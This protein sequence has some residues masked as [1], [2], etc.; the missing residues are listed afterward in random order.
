[1]PA[2]VLDELTLIPP[3][4]LGVLLQQRRRARELS[5]DEVAAQGWLLASE[6]DNLEHGRMIV[7]DAIATELARLYR[8]DVGGITPQRSRLIIDL[9]EQRLLVGDRTETLPSDAT[10]HLVLGRYLAMVQLLRAWKPNQPF[11]LRADDLAVLGDSLGLAPAT[12]EDQLRQLLESGQVDEGV[13]RLRRRLVVPAAGLLV[14]TTVAGALVLIRSGSSDPTRDTPASNSESA[15]VAP[16]IIADVAPAETAVADLPETEVP[17]VA[18]EVAAVEEAA[19][20]EE[21][22]AVEQPATV[23]VPAVVEEPAVVEPPVVIEAPAVIGEPAVVTPTA[24]A[25]ESDPAAAAI[26]TSAEALVT[27]PW[28]GVL[29][30]WTISYLD[31]TGSVTGNTNVP[32]RVITIRIPADADVGYVSEVFAHELGH[33]LDVTYLDDP[34]RQRWLDGRGQPDALW[35]P[36]TGPVDFH[37]GAGDFAEAVAAWLTRSP[38]DSTLA[39]DFTDEQLDLL[40]ELLP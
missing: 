35:W 6:L 33:A 38:S 14:G 29:A 39:G 13:R 2:E 31:G 20:I 9:E 23:E 18:N 17:D 32:T 3:G 21:P 11:P 37:V 16:L 27:Y 30:G 25:V 22:A 12:V 40:A 7:D 8:I 34:A 1:M 10:P 26:G 4:R 5:I 15:V 28:R 19:A 24:V 36:D